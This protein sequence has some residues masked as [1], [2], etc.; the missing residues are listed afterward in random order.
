LSRIR[1]GA[2][3]RTEIAQAVPMMNSAA[4]TTR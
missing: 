2:G 4:A 1:A 3:D